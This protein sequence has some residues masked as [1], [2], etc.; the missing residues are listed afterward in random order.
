VEESDD[1]GQVRSAIRK[2]GNTPTTYSLKWETGTPAIECRSFSPGGQFKKAWYFTKPHETF[3]VCLKKRIN[4]EKPHL[5][6]GCDP[7]NYSRNYKES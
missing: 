6:T 7:V 1:S 3:L 4:P 5:Q 2:R